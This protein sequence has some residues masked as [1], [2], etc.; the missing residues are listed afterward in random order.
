MFYN[1]K[2]SLKTVQ[3]LML[4]EKYYSG[5]ILHWS[6]SALRYCK[7]DPIQ[8]GER[9]LNNAHPEKANTTAVF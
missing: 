4:N 5:V 7:R 6:I 2:M 3:N 1:L 8:N 9:D